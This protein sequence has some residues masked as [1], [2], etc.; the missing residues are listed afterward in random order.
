MTHKH[1]SE[2]SILITSAWFVAACAST[3]ATG[4][5]MQS[6]LGNPSAQHGR[7]CPM[8][9]PD[10]MVKASD[11]T[12]GAALD[13]TT[14]TDHVAEVRERVRNIAAVYNHHESGEP[15][16]GSANADEYISAHGIQPALGMP[17]GSATATDIADGA[18]LVL[19]PADPS[20]LQALRDRARLHT[21][22]VTQGDCEHSQARGS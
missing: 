20:Q 5:A 9:M 12:D 16:E 6:D 21:G 10:S 22:H 2:I 15:I 17:V 11:V 1:T 8:Q 18:R 7:L 3:S 14:S 13:F 4:T 19:R